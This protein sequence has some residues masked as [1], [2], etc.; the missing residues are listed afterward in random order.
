MPYIRNGAL[1]VCKPLP[2][3]RLSAVLLICHLVY[4]HMAREHIYNAPYKE[5]KSSFFR[6]GITSQCTARGGVS[7][8]A[9]MRPGCRPRGL[10]AEENLGATCH[11]TGEPGAAQPGGRT[12]FL[13]RSSPGNRECVYTS[14]CIHAAY[15][16]S[17]TVEVAVHAGRNA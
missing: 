3:R 9:Y 1:Y 5:Y 2:R 4:E 17:W 13:G 8:C 15:A 12:L 6:R 11:L 14:G 16:C 10:A 7:L